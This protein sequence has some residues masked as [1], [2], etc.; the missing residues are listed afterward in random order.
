[1]D[2]LA[3]KVLRLQDPHPIHTVGDVAVAIGR[4]GGHMNCKSD[5]LPGWITLWHSLTQLNLLVQGVL[6]A[7]KMNE[8]G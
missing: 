7:Q 8:F 3:L 6:L 2:P 1:M 4:L 5:S